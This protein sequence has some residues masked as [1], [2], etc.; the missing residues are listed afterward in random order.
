MAP[1]RVGLVGCGTISKIYLENARKFHDLDVVACADLVPERAQA[2]AAEYGVPRAL[3][4]DELLAD[5]EI[6]VVLNLTIPAAH[7]EIGRAALAAG[8]SVYGEKPLAVRREDGAQLLGAARQNGLRVGSAPD[9]FLGGGIQTCRQLIDEG[10]IGAPVAALAFFMNHGHE[11]WH[12]D[13]DFYYQPGA[14]PMFDMGP[15]YLTAMVSLLGPVRRVTGSARISFPERTITSKP[16]SGEKISVNTPTHVAGV[17][18]FQSGVVATIVTSFD[19]W[20]S[21]LPRIEIYGSEGTLGVPDPN[22]FG[23]PV[24]IRRPGERAWSDVPLTHGYTANSRGLGLADLARAIREGRPHRANGDLAYHVLDT[25]QAFLDASRE[26][27]HIEIESSVERPAPMPSGDEQDLL[28][29]I[30]P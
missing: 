2:R 23:G 13:P 12:P 14:G 11:H 18:D 16:R 3:A 17:M 21:E 7:A 10:A 4:V 27:R 24:R 1:V 20:P 29:A 19:V 30:A 9:T 8:K 6:E 5:P 15:Y 25:M 28:G 22:T 26:G